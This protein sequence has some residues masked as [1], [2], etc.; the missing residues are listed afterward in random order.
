MSCR[1]LILLSVLLLTACPKDQEVVETKISVALPE[2]DREAAAILTRIELELYSPASEACT[3]LASW[4]RDVCGQECNRAPSPIDRGEQPI[5]T[6]TLERGEMSTWTG[7]RL[8]VPGGGPW[9]LL[10]RGLDETGKT[11][12]Y[13]CGAVASG[14]QRA[15]QLWR[16]WC[17]TAA[18][19]GQVHPACATSIDCQSSPSDEDPDQLAPP[20]C[21]VSPVMEGTPVR[22]W[23][24]GGVPCPLDQ[25]RP[26][27]TPC[28]EAVFLCTIGQVDPIQDGICP[29]RGLGAAR[30]APPGEED[31]DCDGVVLPPC[32]GCDPRL[33]E[34]QPCM[35]TATCTGTVTC[36]A[37]G[38]YGDRCEREVSAEI[39]DGQNND[40]D[41][42]TDEAV[43]TVPACN[44]LT[45][46]GPPVADD[47][48]RGVCACGLGPACDG[49]MAC[50]T[51]MCRD[52]S[53]DVR[54]CGRCR[55]QCSA[56]QDCRAG[57]CVDPFDAG[58]STDAS[59]FPDA[60][61]DAGIDGGLT[62][63]T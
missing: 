18:C 62:R 22:V 47:C 58:I 46:G 34:E 28:R 12:L 21:V 5:R 37:D 6:L 60:T 23:E 55:R 9:E 41:A 45:D 42:L 31:D 2:R 48:L 38:T 29:G 39:C 43:D 1:K 57:Q 7:E 54:H 63:D 11:F 52:V 33:G 8:E 53:S 35:Y 56:G 49:G 4:R 14:K 13:S 16:P 36:N 50:C 20:S 3:R 59:V 61:R 10:L 25:A 15:F 30:C 40:C 27:S 44:A 24:E 19:A 26:F 51:G 17:D 32:G